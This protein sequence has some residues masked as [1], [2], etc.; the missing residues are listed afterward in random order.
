MSFPANMPYDHNRAM[1]RFVL[2]PE[3]A[4]AVLQHGAG[5]LSGSLARNITERPG[6]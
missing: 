4:I 6:I 2:N 1:L 3:Q 5:V